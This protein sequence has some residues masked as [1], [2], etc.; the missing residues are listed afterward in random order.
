MKGGLAM[1]HTELDPVILLSVSWS[2][3]TSPDR[4]IRKN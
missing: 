4:D 1:S 3:R 2:D